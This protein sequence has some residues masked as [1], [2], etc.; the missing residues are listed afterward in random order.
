MSTTTYHSM[1]GA[2]ATGLLWAF[3]GVTSVPCQDLA[4]VAR[5]NI[6][7]GC[8]GP[9]ELSFVFEVDGKDAM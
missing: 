3:N 6:M 5:P 8:D 9:M 7:K 2:D 4:A 1:T